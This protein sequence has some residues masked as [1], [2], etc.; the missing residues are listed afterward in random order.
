MSKHIFKKIF[1]VIRVTIN[2]VKRLGANQEKHMQHVNWQGF[3]I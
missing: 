3:N 1:Q 2:T